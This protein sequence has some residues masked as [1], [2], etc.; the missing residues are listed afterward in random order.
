LGSTICNFMALRY[1][2]LD[3]SIAIQF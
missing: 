1:L 2:Q 3:E